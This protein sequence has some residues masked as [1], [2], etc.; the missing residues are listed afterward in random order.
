MKGI[1]YQPVYWNG[2]PCHARFVD[3]IVG[4]ADKETYWYA[5]HEGQKRKA[6]QVGLET[7]KGNVLFLLDNEDG[8]ALEKITV[9]R[10][11]P[12]WGHKSI[13]GE[14]CE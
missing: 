1:I 12:P 11:S 14:I 4:K 10:G 5:K 8:S 9:G 7:P 2:E 3:I 6:I 13:K